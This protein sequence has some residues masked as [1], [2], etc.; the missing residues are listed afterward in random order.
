MYILQKITRENNNLKIIYEK[1]IIKNQSINAINEAQEFKEKLLIRENLIKKNKILNKKYA[2]YNKNINDEL[3]PKKYKLKKNKGNKKNLFLECKINLDSVNREKYQKKLKNY[4]YNGLMLLE[5]LINIIKYFLNLNYAKEDFFQNCKNRNKLYF[6]DINISLIKE[7]DIKTI[8][9]NILKAISF[10]EEICK[11]T[12]FT[13]EK[14]KLNKNNLNFIQE[15]ENII[16]YTKRKNNSIKEMLAKIEKEEEDRKK[17]YEKAVKP[18]LFFPN[19]IN[20]ENKILKNVIKNARKREIAK[21]L[22][23]IEF[24]ELVKYNN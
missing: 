16:N 20:C 6:L 19:K 17:T 5:K 9:T 8:N 18:I 15:Q 7:T 12:I 22:D 4:K 13:H 21:R 10:Y 24:N 11:Y 14:L 23:E 1:D 3:N 2:Y